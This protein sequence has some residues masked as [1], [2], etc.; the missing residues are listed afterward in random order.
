MVHWFFPVHAPGYDTQFLRG[1]QEIILQARIVP[2]EARLGLNHAALGVSVP[3]R[4][5]HQV[6]LNLEFKL[7]SCLW[8]TLAAKCQISSIFCVYI[9]V[10]ANQV[11]GSLPQ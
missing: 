9:Y 10:E 1:F 7:S 3:G 5:R 2:L 8:S 4:G 6:H 11:G